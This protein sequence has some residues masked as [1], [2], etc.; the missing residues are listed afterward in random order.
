[1]IHQLTL[2]LEDLENA[3]E[4]TR[5]KDEELKIKQQWA[6][7][8]LELQQKNK[9][10][11]ALRDEKRKSILESDLDG[12]KDLEDLRFQSMQESRQLKAL[13]REAQ[14]AILEIQQTAFEYK[15]S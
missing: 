7:K 4:L 15:T 13:K 9:I 11:K 5:L 14:T 3:Q 1:E 12:L 6:T 2:Q 8:I 10:A